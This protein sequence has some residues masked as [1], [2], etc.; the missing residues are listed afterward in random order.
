MHG[1]RTGFH[2][3]L[4]RASAS[5]HDKPASQPDHA[6]AKRRTAFRLVAPA[7]SGKRTVAPRQLLPE[8]PFA[9]HATW[10]STN[11]AAH[12]GLPKAFRPQARDVRAN[13]GT[14][15]ICS[16]ASGVART[17]SASTSPSTRPPRGERSA[18]LVFLLGACS[19]WYLK[20]SLQF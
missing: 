4:K 20:R 15:E 10:L 14:P 9:E 17:C 5:R 6:L 16:E 1:G 8:R 12:S 13:G 2:D 7:T 3:I 11:R 19:S 18:A